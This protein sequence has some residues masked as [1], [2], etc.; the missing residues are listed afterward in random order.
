MSILLDYLLFYSAVIILLVS[1]VLSFKTRFVQIRLLPKM[2]R[3]LYG[4]L[5]RDS[6]K[7]G[8]HT[9][10]AHKALFTAMS[11]TLGLSTIV[12]PV[13][14]MHLGGPG[15]LLGFVVTAIF[16]PA[17]NFAE[18]TM[19]MGYRKRA[20]DGSILGGP[21]QYLKEAVSPWLARWYALACLCMMVAWSSA[22]AN[23]LA[24]VMSMPLLG[25]W[26]ID[27]LLTASVVAVSVLT[28]L[29]GGI[30]RIGDVSAKLVPAMFVLFVGGA[31]WIIL[32]HLG[33]LPRVFDLIVS[34]ALSPQA[35]GSGVVVGGIAQALRWGVFKGIH[36][37][38]AGIGTQTIPHSMAENDLPADQGLLSMAATYSA[39]IVSILSG[40]V[41]LLTGT[42]HDSSLPLGIS[43]VVESFRQSYSHVGTAV[44]MISTLLFAFG[45][46][47]GNSYNGGEC[48][49]FLSKSRFLTAYYLFTSCGIFVGSL[50]D[51]SFIWTATDFFLAPLAVP[52]IL[53]ILLLAYKR[54]DLLQ[55]Q[56]EMVA[57]PN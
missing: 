14:A 12:G 22:Q 31:G 37:S 35:F 57:L 48:F 49:R 5:A 29:L 27:P 45:T 23:Q 33:D 18:V 47:L 51:A 54:G 25:E 9:I 6:A 36:S 4:F 16:G 34:S 7:E 40:L 30:K 20:A 38:E 56:K 55:G 52:H 28:I 39:G 17:A 1:I 13:V 19:A 8:A 41:V 3:Q 50:S 26:K 21:M 2:V 43:M 15:A 42:L 46:I 10:G 32:S 53:A 11:T 44:V 24:S